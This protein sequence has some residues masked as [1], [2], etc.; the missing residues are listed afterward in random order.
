MAG[1]AFG[2]MD[3]TV[4]QTDTA[5]PFPVRQAVDSKVRLLAFESIMYWLWDFNLSK[6]KFLICKMEI[7]SGGSHLKE[8]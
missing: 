3:I 7:D 5:W 1:T 8:R 2:A 4:N 6:A